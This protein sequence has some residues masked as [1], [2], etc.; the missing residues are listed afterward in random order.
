MKFSE[1]GKTTALIC[2]AIMLS[3]LFIAGLLLFGTSIALEAREAL[4]LNQTAFASPTVPLRPIPD[5]EPA[6]SKN[7]GTQP[8]LPSI[9]P[10]VVPNPY[11]FEY[12]ESPIEA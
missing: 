8:T 5:N 12:V 1:Q 4:R 3:A 10:E 11:Y 6:A 7:S 2:A 9:P